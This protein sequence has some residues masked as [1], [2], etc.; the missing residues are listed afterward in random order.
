VSEKSPEAFDPI[1]SRLAPDLGLILPTGERGKL[2]AY[3]SELLAWNASTNL[4]GR[5]SRED[6][7]RHALE[8]I[9][10]APV[11]ESGDRLVDVG[12]GGGLPGIPLAIAG[13]EVTLLEPRERRAAFLRHVLRTVPGLKASVLVD[14]VEKLSASRF[15]AATV[16]AVGTLGALIG[17]GDFLEKD[18]KLV[19]WTTDPDKNAKDLGG[20]FELERVLSVPGASRRQIAVFRKRSTWNTGDRVG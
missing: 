2:A 20:G 1:L 5:L 14:R 19:I 18:G 15:D 13:L 17:K 3:L 4:F 9:L 10:G 6:L 11:F 16:R 7:A 12:S 8:S